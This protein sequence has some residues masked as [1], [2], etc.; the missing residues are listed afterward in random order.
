VIEDKFKC[1]VCGLAQFPDL[2]WGENG[3]ESSYEICPCCGVEFGHEDD[4]LLNCLRLRRQWVEDRHCGWWSP[5]LRPRDWDIPAQIRGIASAFE[6]AEDEQLIRSYLDAAEPPPRG[7][8]A[9]A[10][11]EKRGR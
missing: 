7:L 8:A 10:R 4:G 2:P 1:R 11:A 3:K 6:G 5:R 9:L